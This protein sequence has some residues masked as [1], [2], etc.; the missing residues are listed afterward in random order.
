MERSQL[1][2]PADEGRSCDD[3]QTDASTSAERKVIAVID[4]QTLFGKLEEGFS[5]GG[6]ATGKWVSG[7]LFFRHPLILFT[8]LESMKEMGG[9]FGRVLS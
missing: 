1:R 6:D 8:F 5:V 7:Q 3:K 4:Q 9:G 2:Y